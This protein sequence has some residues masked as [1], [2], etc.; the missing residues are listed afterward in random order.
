MT[1]PIQILAQQLAAARAAK[2]DLPSDQIVALFTAAKKA[3]TDPADKNRIAAQEIFW[4]LPK[5][6]PILTAAILAVEQEIIAHDPNAEI[7]RRA[8]QTAWRSCEENPAT[9]TA[10]LPVIRIATQDRNATLSAQ[11][12]HMQRIIF[13]K[14]PALN[15]EKPAAPP[16]TQLAQSLAQLPPLNL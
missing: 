8:L 2:R 3:A 14:H 6:N 12:R 1:E 4:H 16:L 11:A 5:T 7:R 13:E 15:T 10:A 9:V